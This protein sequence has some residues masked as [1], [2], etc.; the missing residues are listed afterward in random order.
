[1]AECMTDSHRSILRKSRIFLVSD[2]DIGI[3]DHL[4]SKLILTDEDEERIN[5]EPVRHDK[6][7]RL[8]EILPRRGDEAYDKFLEVLAAQQDY[9]F[10][11]VKKVER[12]DREA[13]W[14]SDSSSSYSSLSS[15]ECRTVLAQ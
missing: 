11:Q 2:L 10:D 3:V 9:L 7:K 5:A 13:E 8:L 14:P 15:G 4:V 1:M 12:Q 6:V